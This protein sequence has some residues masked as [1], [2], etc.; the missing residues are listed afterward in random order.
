MTMARDLKS[1]GSLTFVV[2]SLKDPRV[3]LCVL[4]TL[5]NLLGQTTYYFNRNLTE[6]AACIGTA[7][8]LDFILMMILFRQVALPMSAYITGLSI[9]LLLESLDWRVYVCAAV[10]GILSK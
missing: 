9:A 2:P 4:L 7:C 1:F 8:A 6:L 10:W 5:W 3:M